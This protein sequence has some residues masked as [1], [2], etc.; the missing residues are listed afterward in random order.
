MKDLI[1]AVRAYALANYDKGWDVVYEAWTDEEIAEVI[2]KARTVKS[3]IS[4]VGKEVAIYNDYAD[5]ICAS[6]F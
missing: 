4:R 2:G 5:D 1:A 6:A 3:A